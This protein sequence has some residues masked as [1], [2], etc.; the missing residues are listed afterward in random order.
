MVPAIRIG[1]VT[2]HKAPRLKHL[3]SASR[4]DAREKTSGTES[5]NKA[6]RSSRLRKPDFFVTDSLISQDLSF[7]AEYRIHLLTVIVTPL[8][9]AKSAGLEISERHFRISETLLKYY[10]TSSNRCQSYYFSVFWID[11]IA[12]L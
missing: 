8:V 5:S 7:I 11:V 3:K 12:V 2:A 4:R 1:K 10:M 9:A 6:T